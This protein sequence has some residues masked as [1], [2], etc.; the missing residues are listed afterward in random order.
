MRN[1]QGWLS[2]NPT[3]DNRGVSLLKNRMARRVLEQALRAGRADEDKLPD[4]FTKVEVVKEVRVD[5][6]AKGVFSLQFNFDSTLL[7]VGFNAG[8]IKIHDTKTGEETSVLRPCRHGGFPIMCLRFHPKVPHILFACDAEGHIYQYNL[9]DGT[10]SHVITEAG[11][12]INAMDF[13]VDGYNF[14]TAGRDLSVRIYDTKT[15]RLDKTFE[16]YGSGSFFKGS[17][18][19]ECGNTMRVYALKFIPENEFTFIT[20][21]WD[22]HLKIW[23]TRRNDGMVRQIPGPHVCGDSIDIKGKTVLAGSWRANHALEEYN[24]FNEKQKPKEIPFPNKNG[25]FLYC[26]Q[27]CEN[28]VVLAGGSGTNSVEAIETSTGRHIGG[29]KMS[30][31]VQALDCA[32]GGRVFAVGGADDMFKLCSM[33]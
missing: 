19:M 17:Q 14:A 10:S 26:A 5:D 22:N 27:Y 1:N 13:S 33:K 30:R 20:A 16:G 31:T 11:N 7:A 29:V 6:Y 2:L 28:N 12:E 3:L 23:D 24:Y 32:N 15:L 21:G 18:D 4:T 25:A 8:G 9:Q